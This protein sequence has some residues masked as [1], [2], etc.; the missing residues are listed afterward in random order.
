MYR[1]VNNLGEICALSLSKPGETGPG[2]LEGAQVSQAPIPSQTRWGSTSQNTS[3]PPS[4]H[5]IQVGL[6]LFL[7]EPGRGQARS[8][9]WS[10]QRLLIPWGGCRET[11]NWAGVG[12]DTSGHSEKPF[13]GK[14][15]EHF[16]CFLGIQSFSHGTG[17]AP[18]W[19]W[20]IIPLILCPAGVTVR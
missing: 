19:G 20:N 6:K 9:R 10:H 16:D 14:K 17:T 12:G 2:L 3:V 11:Q 4:A 15:K 5:G 7:H 1:V 8:P 18:E 13:L